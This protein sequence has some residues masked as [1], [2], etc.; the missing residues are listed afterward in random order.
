MATT[1]CDKCGRGFTD[2]RS[3]KYHVEHKV[4]EKAGHQCKY[5]SGNF[6][7]STSMYRHIRDTCKIKKKDEEMRTNIY[8]RLLNLENNN[9]I[10]MRENEKLKEK[11]INME[12][13]GGKIVT[14]N[15]NFGN[16]QYNINN[17]HLVAHGQEDLSRIDKN[18]LLQVFRSGF[19]STLRLTETMH[20]N[21]EYPEYHNVYISSMKNK[22]AM[23][24]DGNDW[25]LVMKDELIDKMYD[26]KRT[27]IE[28]NLDDFLDS[29]TTS[30]KNALHRWMDADDEHDYIKKI[31]NGI[32]LLLYN[33]RKMPLR[34]KDHC[35]EDLDNDDE[36]IICDLLP[37]IS[38]NDNDVKVIKVP[39]MANN[40]KRIKCAGRPGTK[41][42]IVKVIRRR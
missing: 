13:S 25:T 16:I 42:K 26:N 11:M 34:L 10:L 35:D 23:L 9:T 31:K 15:V 33:K 7:T 30:Q 40:K 39:K 6:T 14:N 18:E 4:C 3:K 22:Y 27:Y 1:A 19:N 20:F 36:V 28:E 12:N 2:K 8:E 24:Y 38:E 21:P 17:I 5:C 32:K 37:E 41:R 29:L